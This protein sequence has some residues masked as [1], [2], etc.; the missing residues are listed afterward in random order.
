MENKWNK[1]LKIGFLKLLK[2]NFKV[3]ITLTFL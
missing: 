3:K 2:E 1:I